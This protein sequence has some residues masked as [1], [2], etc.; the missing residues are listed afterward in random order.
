ME[1]ADARRLLPEPYERAL[2]LHEDGADDL[3]IAADLGIVPEA[4]GLLLRLGEIKLSQLLKAEAEPEATA[5]RP[6]QSEQPPT[7]EPSD[8]S[9]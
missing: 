5:T 3:T 9:H 4:V 7:Q 2:E 8:T 1:R 6:E